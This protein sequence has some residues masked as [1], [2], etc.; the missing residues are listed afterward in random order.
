MIARKV[1]CSHVCAHFILN[2]N[3]WNIKIKKCKA[4]TQRPFT[5]Q[6]A[7]KSERGRAVLPGLVLYIYRDVYAYAI[8]REVKGRSSAEA[9]ERSAL[10]IICQGAQHLVCVR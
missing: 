9:E 1:C 2:F 10:K 6:T 8:G 3:L 4:Q 7:R 5:P